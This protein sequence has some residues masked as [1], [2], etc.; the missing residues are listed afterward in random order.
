MNRRTFLCGAAALSLQAKSGPTIAF[1]AAASDRLAVASY[2]FRNEF[3]PGGMDLQQFAKMVPE[4]F[5][6][7]AIEPLDT[8]FRSLDTAYLIELRESF[9]K[10]GVRVV[11]IPL[12]VHQCLY[13]PDA[14]VRAAGV[15]HGKRWIDAAVTL[16][17]PSVRVH[18]PGAKGIPPDV[19]RAAESLTAIAQYG[20]MKN[21][22]VNLEN[23]DLESEDA[24]FI[25]DVINRVHSPW[26]NALPD[27]CNSMLRGDERFN[28][29]A[30]TAMF[31]RAYNISH[32][33]DSESD[34]GK[35]FR[36]DMDRTFGIAKAAGYRGFFSMEWEG[37]ED[38][39]TGTKK[40][41][42]SSLK[43]LSA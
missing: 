17:S 14:A 13:H 24:F 10:S 5:G 38:P 20:E 16:G 41:I 22:A 9:K 25:V 11:N 3:K 6:V 32:V 2:P 37:V 21:V 43:N 19:K 34:N 42:A 26:L 12:D 28:Y 36:V 39:Y 4:R 29:D 15:E 40:L 23:D 7:H 18:I 27:F 31:K 8:H 33:K 1:P 35:V 30:V